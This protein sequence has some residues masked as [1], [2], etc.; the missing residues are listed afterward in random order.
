MD[1]WN[2]ENCGRSNEPHWERC[3]QCRELPGPVGMARLRAG[4]IRLMERIGPFPEPSLYG[5]ARPVNEWSNAEI[6]AW[7]VEFERDVLDALELDPMR[8]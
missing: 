4:L 1:G 7:L 2:C 6:D 8:N 3:L 5:F